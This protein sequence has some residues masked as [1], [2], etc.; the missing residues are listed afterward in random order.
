MP[1]LTK[2]ESLCLRE[3]CGQNLVTVAT[4]W[5]NNVNMVKEY[6]HGNTIKIRCSFKGEGNIHSVRFSQRYDM[7]I[8]QLVRCDCHQ[9]QPHQTELTDFWGDI[10][11]IVC[12]TAIVHHTVTCLQSATVS[13]KPWGGCSE[14]ERP[15]VARRPLIRSWWKL[16]VEKSWITYSRLGNNR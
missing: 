14:I 16:W 12:K 7:N 10:L 5:Y 11:V 1:I 3:K 13:G 9:W 4:A 6:W 15:G 8:S 2:C